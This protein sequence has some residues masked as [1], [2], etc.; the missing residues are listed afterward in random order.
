MRHASH[1]SH[2]NFAQ[3]TCS[4]LQ[5]HQNCPCT[6]A[7]FPRSHSN[8]AVPGVLPTAATATLPLQTCSPLQPQQHC[9]AR[10][11]P[12]CSH[13]NIAIPDV[14]PT[15][16]TATLPSQTCSPLQPQQHCSSSQGGVLPRGYVERERA[17]LV[18]RRALQPHFNH[19]VCPTTRL[20]RKRMRIWGAPP[21]NSPLFCRINHSPPR[22]DEG[23]MEGEDG[24]AVSEGWL[25]GRVQLGRLK[26]EGW[27]AG[28]LKAEC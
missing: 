24:G 2:G 28:R 13:S 16:A 20:R 19:R 5:P 1:C 18:A 23:R 25:D 6:R 3:H 15:A 14:L 21:L 10:R 11:A 17:C 12:Y 4:P 26:I 7:S 8:I 9:P 27:M 22:Q